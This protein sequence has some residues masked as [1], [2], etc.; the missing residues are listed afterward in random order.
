MSHQSGE[1]AKK[2]TGNINFEIDQGISCGIYSNI[3]SITNSGDE[4][5]LDFAFLH[6]RRG[7]ET[8]KASVRSR[9]I[10]SPSHAKKL[11]LALQRNIKIYEDRFGGIRI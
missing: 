4:F 3:A 8:A 2:E 11:C 10:V 6:P 7:E 5:I 9:I 1:E